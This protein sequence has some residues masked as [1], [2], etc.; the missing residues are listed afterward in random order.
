M[1][2][3]GS[4]QVRLV[5]VETPSASPFARSLLFGYV[6]MFLYEADAPLAQR[7]AQELA[8]YPASRAEL[9]GG[10]ERRELLDGDAIA[11]L[12]AELQRLVLERHGRG[13]HGVHDLLRT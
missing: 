7:R 12:E 13:L 11:T 5:E 9:L 10:T 8:L 1:R 2:E 6:G 3:S 4:R